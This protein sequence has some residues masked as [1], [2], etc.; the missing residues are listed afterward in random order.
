LNFSAWRQD[1]CGGIARLK[2]FCGRWGIFVLLQLEY[3]VAAAEVAGF[4]FDGG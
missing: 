4:L 1:L 2:R 3:D